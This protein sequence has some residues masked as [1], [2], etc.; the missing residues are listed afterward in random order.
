M[1][2]E[3]P[4]VTLL[5]IVNITH[6]NLLVQLYGGTHGTDSEWLVHGRIVSVSECGRVVQVLEEDGD[7]SMLRCEVIN[8][9]CYR[10]P[11][12]SNFDET[13]DMASEMIQ[14]ERVRLATKDGLVHD[15]KLY[16]PPSK[17]KR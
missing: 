5:R 14:H 11:G 12:A 3:H 15:V 9:I 7:M 10:A 2:Q 17:R 16:K 8:R 1:T 4:L 6:P 13:D